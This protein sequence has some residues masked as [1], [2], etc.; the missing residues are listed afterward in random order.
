M[1]PQ[2]GQLSIE[3]EIS[4]LQFG[5]RSEVLTFDGAIFRLSMLGRQEHTGNDY[6]NFVILSK[7]LLV[8]VSYGKVHRLFVI[9]SDSCT[10]IILTVGARMSTVD[11]NKAGC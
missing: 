9:H 8:Q 3:P 1:S 6:L 2:K 11:D 5:Q 10:V 7:T 4:F